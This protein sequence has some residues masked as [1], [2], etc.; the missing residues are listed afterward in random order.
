LLPVAPEEVEFVTYDKNKLGVWSAFHLSKEYKDGSATGSQQNSVI[1]ITHQ[2]LDTTIERSAHLN[3][4]ATTTFVSL[5]D[6]LRVVPFNL[7]PALRVRSV[8]DEKHQPLSFIQEDKN[9]DADFSVILPRPLSLGEKFTIVTDYDGKDAVRNE[10]GGNYYPVAREDWYPNNATAGLVS[11][12]RLRHDI[13]CSQGNENGR[14]R[15]AGQR[16]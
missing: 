3:G 4:K 2:Q 15:R 13:P 9:D 5:A 7:F 8:V 14:D 10:G 16:Q 11:I 12:Y 1:Q 6:G